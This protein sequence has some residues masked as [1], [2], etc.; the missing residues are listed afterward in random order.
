MNLVKFKR[1]ISVDIIRKDLGNKSPLWYILNKL[2]STPNYVNGKALN[3]GL[4]PPYIF[5]IKGFE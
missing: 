3:N 5:A 2:T 4:I 1:N